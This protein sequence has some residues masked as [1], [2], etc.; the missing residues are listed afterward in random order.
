MVVDVN[1]NMLAWMMAMGLEAPWEYKRHP[2]MG[3]PSWIRREK[4]KTVCLLPGCEETT[5]HNG[6]YCKA[7]H[8]AEHRMQRHRAQG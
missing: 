3:L 4:P 7:E 8:C 2:S 5:T 6:G 1:N